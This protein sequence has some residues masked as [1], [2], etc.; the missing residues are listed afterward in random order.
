MNNPYKYRPETLAGWA[1]VLRQTE[2]SRFLFVRPEGGTPA[3]RENLWRAFEAG[4]VARD[5]VEFVAVRGTHLRHYNAIDI[6][7]DTFP[8]TGGTTTCECLWMG[9]PVVTLVGE[10]F[11]E[12]LSHSNLANAG[13]G[14]LSAFS[15]EEYVAKAVALAADRPRRRDLRAGLRAQIRQQPLGRVDLFVDDLQ[16]AIERVVREARR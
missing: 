3:F 1:E 5:R 7:L 10:A 6:A 9:V 14:E 13:L 16:R 4:G 15:R 8:Q 11:F 2:G 12:R